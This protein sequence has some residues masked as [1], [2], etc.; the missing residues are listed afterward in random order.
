MFLIRSVTIKFL[1]SNTRGFSLLPIQPA[2]PVNQV[3]IF[4]ASK[5]KCNFSCILSYKSFC[6][7]NQAPT[8]VFKNCRRENILHPINVVTCHGMSNLGFSPSSSPSPIK[9]EGTKVVIQTVSQFLS[10]TKH[11]VKV[12]DTVHLSSFIGYLFPILL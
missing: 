11:G 7:L 4:R 1:K 6:G 12:E 2:K 10:Y 3:L 9:G 5:L 8:K